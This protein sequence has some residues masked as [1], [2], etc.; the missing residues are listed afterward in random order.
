MFPPDPTLPF[1]M[2]PDR[3]V[4]AT[5]VKSGR[6][7]YDVVY[8]T[9]AH[10]FRAL[11]PRPPQPVDRFYRQDDG[12]PTALLNRTTASAL[13]EDFERGAVERGELRCAR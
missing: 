6:T 8:T 7:I 2:L 1:R 10:G 3:R 12:H 9:D 11:L 5:S 4:R 13:V